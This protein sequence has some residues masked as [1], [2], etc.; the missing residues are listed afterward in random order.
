M[1]EYINVENGDRVV[2]CK[3]E[4]CGRG[5]PNT[6]DTFFYLYIHK[7]NEMLPEFAVLTLDESKKLASMIVGC[8]A[9]E[10]SQA[11]CGTTD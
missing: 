7:E 6:T 11:N 4:H 8:L 1:V 10:S 9:D 5:L 3:A 2:F